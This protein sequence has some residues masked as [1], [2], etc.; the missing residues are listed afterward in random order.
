MYFHVTDLWRTSSHAVHWACQFCCTAK[1]ILSVSICLLLSWIIMAVLAGAF[2]MDHLSMWFHP[3]LRWSTSMGSLIS[4]KAKILFVPFKSMHNFGQVT[5]LTITF[6]ALN[7]TGNSAQT[8]TE[9][10]SKIFFKIFLGP[11]DNHANNI[12]SHLDYS[13]SFHQRK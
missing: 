4:S 7:M 6:Y 10:P 12:F 1:T 2:A 8:I 9:L 11:S 5:F 3:S 13:I